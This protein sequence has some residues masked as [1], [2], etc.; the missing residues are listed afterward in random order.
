MLKI[1]TRKSTFDK[2]TMSESY[3]LFCFEERV[4]EGIL[5]SNKYKGDHMI[6]KARK[7]DEGI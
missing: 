6:E 7:F 3:L 2:M 5:K 4:Y 1:L